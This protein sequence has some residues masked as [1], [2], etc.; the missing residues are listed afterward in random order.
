MILVIAVLEV[1]QAVRLVG[2][3]VG[4]APVGPQ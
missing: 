1:R 4:V 3:D 2:R